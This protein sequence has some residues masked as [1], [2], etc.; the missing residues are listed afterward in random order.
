M[1]YTPG[2]QLKHATIYFHRRIRISSTF[3]GIQCPSDNSCQYGHDDWLSHRG[4]TGFCLGVRNVALST[5][6]L[7]YVHGRKRV[8]ITVSQSHSLLLKN[9]LQHALIL[10]AINIMAD[11]SSSHL[12]QLANRIQVIT[13]QIVDSIAKSGIRE[14]SFH[15]TSEPIPLTQAHVRL[16]NE[17]NDTAADLLRL[18]NGPKTDIQTSICTI[19]DLAAW[20]VACEFNIF[21][22]VP[23]TGSISVQEIA[24]K[25]GVDGDRIGRIMRILATDRVFAETGKDM[26]EHTSRSILYARDQQI[27]DAVHYQ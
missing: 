2:E 25:V 20:Q 9:S 12:L 18:V 26:F 5:L 23:Q 15:A 3:N 6:N 27:R 7:Y 21:E 17:L 1:N 13:T 10:Y 8:P 22:A 24:L 19:Y 16:R 11:A 4:D 14:P